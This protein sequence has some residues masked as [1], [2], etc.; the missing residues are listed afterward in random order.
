M[1]KTSWLVRRM[2]WA[3]SAK[4]PLPIVHT[5]PSRQ[6]AR[7]GFLR[8]SRTR[9]ISERI[10]TCVRSWVHDG[11]L[12]G[13]CFQLYRWFYGGT[14]N[15]L[16][17]KTPERSPPPFSKKRVKQKIE[18]PQRQKILAV[19]RNGSPPPPTP[20]TPPPCEAYRCK[21][22]QSVLLELCLEGTDMTRLGIYLWG[23]FRSHF[24]FSVALTHD[25][26]PA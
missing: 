13:S 25:I 21:V 12:I 22:S 6:H 14:S 23:G 16:G 24:P 19:S 7:V 8:P 20:G 10:A 5:S 26:P 2:C 15:P 11:I 17:P 9:G 1:P 18:A 4:Q 3:P